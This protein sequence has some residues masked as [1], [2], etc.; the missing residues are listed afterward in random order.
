MAR[1]RV[2]NGGRGLEIWRVAANVLNKQYR[3]AARCGTPAWGLGKGLTTPHRKN[4]VSYEM[5]H[6]PRGR[7]SRRWDDNN[8][9]NLGEMEWETVDWIHLAQG[10]DLLQALVNMV[11]NFR[12][13]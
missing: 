11:T 3:T 10:S 6:R 13:P 8:R 2:T 9:M 7:P 5:L 12:V 1:P 4:S